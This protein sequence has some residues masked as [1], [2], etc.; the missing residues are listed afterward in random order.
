MDLRRE[1]LPKDRLLRPREVAAMLGI[2]RQEVY[3]SRFQTTLGAVHV[4][5]ALR[6][7]ESAVL[8]AMAHGVQDP[9]KIEGPR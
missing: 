9:A 2:S 6:F 8:A 5:R 7:R 3:S 1:E 4:L